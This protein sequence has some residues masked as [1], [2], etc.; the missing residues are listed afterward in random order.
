MRFLHED[1]RTDPKGFNRSKEVSDWLSA[2][3]EV[4]DYRILDDE[5][6]GWTPEQ[7]AKFLACHPMEGMQSPE[8]EALAKWAGLRP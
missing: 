7:N 3:P 4:C 2:H 5:D 1:W 8:M 6:H